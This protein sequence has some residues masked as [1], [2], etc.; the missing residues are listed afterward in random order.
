[1]VGSGFAPSPL[2]GLAEIG[3]DPEEWIN[4]CVAGTYGLG[5]VVAK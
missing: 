5:S 4:R 3:H 1:M 2:A